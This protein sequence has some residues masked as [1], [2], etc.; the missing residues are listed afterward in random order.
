M[1]GRICE[2]K[3]GIWLHC[4]C[5][6]PRKDLQLDVD[7]RDQSINYPW[8]ICRYSFKFTVLSL[9][10]LWYKRSQRSVVEGFW[11]SP[12][13]TF[14]FFLLHYITEANF[15][16]WFIHLTALV[17]SFFPDY[18]F[19]SLLS[20]M[21]FIRSKTGFPP[22]KRCVCVCVCELP[23]RPEAR[24][25]SPQLS[26]HWFVVGKQT[27]GCYRWIDTTRMPASLPACTSAGSTRLSEELR[28]SCRRENFVSQTFSSF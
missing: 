14:H 16:L 27:A 7:K 25:G 3:K 23:S 2:H 28:P 26:A 17:T 18:S 22:Y 5:K 9:F 24:H 20:I 10:N 4:S 15:T 13:P 11:V 21:K 12:Y 8:T 6:W 1:T 19:P